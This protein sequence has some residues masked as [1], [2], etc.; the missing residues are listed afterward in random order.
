MTVMAIVLKGLSLVLLALS[1]FFL[2]AF[3]LGYEPA[4][5]MEAPICSHSLMSMC[6]LTI[7]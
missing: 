1:V 7:M 6:L 2:V 5:M 3:F 4:A